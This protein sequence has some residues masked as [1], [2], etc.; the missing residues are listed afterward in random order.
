ME[1][2]TTDR[3]DMIEIDN[4]I[5][6]CREILDG[7]DKADLTC[8]QRRRDPTRAFLEIYAK[9]AATSGLVVHI[10]CF[11]EVYN[12][13]RSKILNTLNDESWMK[14]DIV[15]WFGGNLPNVRKNNIKIILS[16]IYKRGLIR[17]NVIESTTTEK[18]RE[19]IDEYYYIDELVY[20]LI[21]IFILV[22]EDTEYEVDIP[23][24]KAIVAE[25]SVDLGMTDEIKKPVAPA[26]NPFSAIT[27]A[28]AGA[29]DQ[30]G[31]KTPDGKPISEMMQ[32]I[33]LSKI[34]EMVSGVLKDES[35]MKNITNTVST[36]GQNI[37]PAQDGTTPG[38]IPQ[39][40]MDEV[41]NNVSNMVGNAFMNSSTSAPGEPEK[42]TEQKEE[43]LKAMKAS[44]GAMMTNA[45]N[46]MGNLFQTTVSDLS[47]SNTEE[48]KV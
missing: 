10:N 29:V 38:Q 31:I 24:L 39:M 18:E 36:F 20:F 46:M 16:D 47:K 48:K 8:T 1:P 40:N 2:A 7:Y 5:S 43:E 32:N 19:N 13:K 41:F 14:E 3:D 34:G 17:H 37:M 12:N 42:T 28:L 4:L 22:I 9:T 15:I 45:T 44:M 23:Q 30:M 26:P 33:D 6:V 25:I 21:K 27:S 35:M 11:L